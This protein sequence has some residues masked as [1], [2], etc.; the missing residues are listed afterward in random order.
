MPDIWCLESLFSLAPP[1]LPSSDFPTLFTPV[2]SPSYRPS[3]QLD[4]VVLF[5]NHHLDSPSHN[6]AFGAATR[7][8]VVVA[9][10]HLVDWAVAVGN[11]TA[12]RVALHLAVVPPDFSDNIVESLVNVD[13]RLS[14]GLDE[15]A[16]EGPRERLTLCY[17]YMLDIRLQANIHHLSS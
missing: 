11:P 12:G 14:G 15:L 17:I 4:P 10:F 6:H 5:G 7:L 2:Q 9:S 1:N 16:A 8:D 13:P 3:S